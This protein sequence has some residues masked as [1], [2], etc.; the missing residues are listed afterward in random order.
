M[1]AFRAMHRASISAARTCRSGAAFCSSSFS[2]GSQIRAGYIAFYSTSS[3]DPGNA[4][5]PPPVNPPDSFNPDAATLREQ[6]NY[7]VRQYS[8]WYSHAWGTAIFAG[9]SLFAVGWVVKGQNPITAVVQ[10]KK[11]ESEQ[12]N[13]EGD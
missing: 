8:K 13:L 2:H 9:M 6:W 4:L 3:T 12:S 1:A 11:A 10:K 7:A 5:P